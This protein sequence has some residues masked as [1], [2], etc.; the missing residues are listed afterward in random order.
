ML[1]FMDH[2]FIFGLNLYIQD[3]RFLEQALQSIVKDEVLFTSSIQ[4][5]LID[6][7]ETEESTKICMPFLN[8]Y[9]E[10]IIYLKVQGATI[11]QGYQL[12]LSHNKAN[13][14]NFTG[15]NTIYGDG[16][17]SQVRE[18]LADSNDLL[19]AIHTK[20]FDPNKSKLEKIKN[21]QV[22]YDLKEQLFY[23][24]LF[25]NRYF[26]ASELAHKF[27][28]RENLHEDCLKEFLVEALY[29]QD[30]ITLVKKTC[31][32]YCDAQERSLQRYPYQTMRWW[33][34]DQM[35]D[36]ILP[37]LEK[38][39]EKGPIPIHI[40]SLLLYLI[41]I[42][43]YFNQN[44]RYKY[45]I[46]KDEVCEFFALVH[47]ALEYIDEA[48]II[49]NSVKGIAPLYLCYQLVQ[50][51]KGQTKLN[52]EF[53]IGGDGK[54]WVIVEDV[55]F[56]PL[57]K[58]IVSL[59]SFETDPDTK[60]KRIRCEL[61]FNYLFNE[62]DMKFQVEVNGK[63]FEIEKDEK[64]N[65]V[66]Y[67]GIV[68]RHKHIFY[69][70]IPKEERRLH[71]KLRFHMMVNGTQQ[72]IK[73]KLARRKMLAVLKRKI[74]N[75]PLCPVLQYMRSIQY[76]ILYLF[77][78]VQNKQLKD[79]VL[80][81]SD[82]RAEL[83]GNLAFIDNELKK[84]NFIVQ[85]FFKRSLK[86][87]KTTQ[88]K[89]ELCRK[90]AI[91]KYIMVDD[92]YPII[93]ALPLR[94]GT[95]LIQVW[96]AMGAFKTVGFSR[97][98]KPGGP[99]PRSISHRNYTDTITSSEGI[100]CNYAE[101]FDMPI[102]DVHAT[103]IP[104]T[105]IFFDKSYIR[106]TKERLYEKYPRLKGK[107]VVMFAPT[108]RGN[109][110]NSAYYNFDWIDF[111][112]LQDTFGKEYLFIIKLHPFIK[113][114]DSVPKDNDFFLDLTCEREINDL[115]FITDILI[116]DYSSVI[117]E[118]SL[119]NIDTIFY[120]PDLKEYTE[121]RDFYYPFERYTFGKI[122]MDMSQLCEAI[123]HPENDTNLLQE[124]KEHF[125]NACDGNATERFV[126]KLF[127]TEK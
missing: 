60:E 109:G 127:L 27:S 43:F 46:R 52:P 108:F 10:N 7:Q 30:T 111:S 39:A 50:I 100:R 18:H 6:S 99:N 25:L 107:K 103:G 44:M 121:S 113:N 93:Y 55:P 122:A 38:Y 106:A 89:K 101:A 88:E 53:S 74:K 45:I 70:H 54:P 34:I 9:P 24:P 31:I 5:I 102:E 76:I 112:V 116:T 40:Q 1:I 49:E 67:F 105:D 66:K 23:L 114:I 32:Y 73:G 14:L 28:F 94:K 80:M 115:L 79:H 120:V 90:M 36:M 20:F 104:R 119:L 117:F 68:L 21:K 98:G 84:N 92:F 125:C 87:E 51:R 81:L 61:F 13:Y 26:I 78:R 110:Q 58:V 2:H 69:I 83:S 47:E 62:K 35:K 124:F 85:Y 11:A 29:Y 3:T 96:H 126:E 97:L 41:E 95:R 75:G 91:S 71:N 15:S 48:V 17:L 56:T 72:E 65:E 64:L 4:L 118:A 59:Q 123:K 37:L 19:T 42:K 8:K 82:S 57:D 63:P 86:E 33:Y 12:A 16:T 77:Y 22:T